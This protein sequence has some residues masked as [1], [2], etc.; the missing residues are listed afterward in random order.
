MGN[1]YPELFSRIKLSIVSENSEE[2]HAS[3]ENY[4]YISKYSKS[5]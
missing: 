1:R 4:E 5:V 3:D 2:T